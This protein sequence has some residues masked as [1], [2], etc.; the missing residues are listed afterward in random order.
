[1][2]AKGLHLTALAAASGDRC[3]HWVSVMPLVPSDAETIAAETGC[4]TQALSPLDGLSQDDIEAGR[5]YFSVMK[6]NLAAIVAS[7]E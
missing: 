3:P 2:N 1:M 4:R 7:F 5:D 6:D